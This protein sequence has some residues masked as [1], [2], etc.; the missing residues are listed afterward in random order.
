MQAPRPASDGPLQ[1]TAAQPS[2]HHAI[3]RIINQFYSAHDGFAP[4]DEEL[5][6]WHKINRPADMR[7]QIMV[8]HVAG[9]LVATCTWAETSLLLQGQ[10]VPVAALADFACR[11]ELCDPADALTGLLASAPQPTIVCLL[12]KNDPLAPLYARAGFTKAVSEVGMLL[13]FSGP[14]HEALAIEPGPWYVM[15]ESVIG[16]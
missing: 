16:I 7:A 3:A 9:E 15:V 13:P 10:N 5:W 4:L 12:D 11:P 14:A 6:E 2:D 8:A 1:L